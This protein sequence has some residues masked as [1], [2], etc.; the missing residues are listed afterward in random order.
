MSKLIKDDF[1][2][3]GAATVFWPLLITGSLTVVVELISS[4]N[5]FNPSPSVLISLIT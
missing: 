4:G 3:E 2:F 5:T 1:D